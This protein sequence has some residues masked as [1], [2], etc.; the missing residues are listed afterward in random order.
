MWGYCWTCGGKALSEA[1]VCLYCWIMCGSRINVSVWHLANEGEGEAA[2][3]AG[4][5]P[6]RKGP[7]PHI[8]AEAL[9]QHSGPQIPRLFPSHGQIS[10]EPWEEPGGQ[11]WG[12]HS[13]IHSPLSETAWFT[14]FTHV[15]WLN[16]R[17]NVWHPVKISDQN[18]APLCR[19][20]KT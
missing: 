13:N 15:F 4:R 1:L 7:Y 20:I 17:W 14:D 19:I 5:Q 8:R 11:L 16:Q 6:G 9:G 18:F 10:G 12:K 3:P 2:D